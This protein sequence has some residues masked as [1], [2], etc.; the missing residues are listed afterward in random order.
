M[1]LRPTAALLLAGLALAGCESPAASPPVEA[2]STFTTTTE[3]PPT[4]RTPVPGITVGS[5]KIVP[6]TV[7]CAG[8]LPT[9]AKATGVKPDLL[10]ESTAD[11]CRYRLPYP[12]GTTFAS[13]F[14]RAEPPGTPSYI[15]VADVDGNSA[16]AVSGGNPSACGLSIALDPYLEPAEHGSHLTVL[17]GFTNA[18][19]PTVA[20]KIADAVFEHLT[21]A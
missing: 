3:P 15:P 12:T 11:L 9:F 19:C 7:D 21:D 6:A 10:Q 16:F 18:P 2:R 4:S 20:R 13:V 17:G 5:P 14:F 8:Y 1:L